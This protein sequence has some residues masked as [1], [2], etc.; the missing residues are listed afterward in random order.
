MKYKIWLMILIS[1]FL[2]AGKIFADEEEYSGKRFFDLRLTAGPGAF[3]YPQYVEDGGYGVNGVGYDL[4]WYG[5]KAL[6]SGELHYFVHPK[7]SIGGGGSFFYAPRPS[8]MDENMTVHVDANDDAFGGYGG[9]CASF[10]VREWSRINAMI[11]YGGTGVKKNYGGTGP[12]FS[13]GWTF[14]FPGKNFMAGIGARFAA[15]RL[16][17]PAQGTTRGESGIYMIMLLELSVDWAPRF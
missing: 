9:V 7:F 14:L 1:S 6:V 11:G 10:Y 17:Y 3:Y 12:L 15:M 16:S 13:A 8:A 4:T 5:F 2:L